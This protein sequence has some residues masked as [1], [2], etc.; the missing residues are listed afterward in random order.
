MSDK[1]VRILTSLNSSARPNLVINMVILFPLCS[2][3][4]GYVGQN[5]QCLIRS[6]FKFEWGQYVTRFSARINE[7]HLQ[8]LASQTH[9]AH[10]D[11]SGDRGIA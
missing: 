5:L 9:A 4:K 8:V 7:T 1:K 3:N 2:V 10:C 6:V 11:A